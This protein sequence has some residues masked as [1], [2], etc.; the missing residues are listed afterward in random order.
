MQSTFS[1]P[2]GIIPTVS[3]YFGYVLIAYSL[4]GVLFFITD[5]LPEAFH[6]DIDV[7]VFLVLL[8]VWIIATA[9]VFGIALAS[10]FPAF[11]VVSEGVSYRFLFFFEGLIAWS[12]IARVIELKLPKGAIAVV[13]SR[14]GYSL[15]NPKGLF[16]NG[17]YGALVVPHVVWGFL[18]PDRPVL[19]LHTAHPNIK[20]WQR[21]A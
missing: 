18:I 11:R 17:W 4:Y 9:G 15:F 6:S 7:A 2:K 16:I 14:K 20:A 19:L 1:S 10:L 21:P 13:V 3:R 8:Y 12:E 5:V